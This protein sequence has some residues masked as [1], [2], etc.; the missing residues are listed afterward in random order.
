MWEYIIPAVASI[1]IAIIEVRAANDRKAMKNKEECAEKRADIRAEESRLA[2]RTQ[3]AT[4][5]LGIATANALTD[6]H[7]NGDVE[8]AKVAAEEAQDEYNEFLQK[9]ASKTITK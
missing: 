6:D 2:M 3:E 7:N 1:I 4:L 8:R 9:V 5:Q